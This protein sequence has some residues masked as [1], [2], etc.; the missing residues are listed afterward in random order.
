MTNYTKG[1]QLE[2]EFLNIM[3]ANGWRGTRTAGSHSE[4]DVILW[5]DTNVNHKELRTTIFVQ[6]KVK[7]K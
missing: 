4:Y 1:V 3:K 7:K 6:C 2:R 5:K